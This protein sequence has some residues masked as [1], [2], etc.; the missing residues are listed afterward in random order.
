LNEVVRNIFAILDRKEKGTLGRLIAFDVIISLLDIVF[1]VALLYIVQF[2]TQSVHPAGT[3]RFPFSAFEKSPLWLIATFFLLFS[4]KNLAGFLVLRMQFRFVYGVASRLSRNNLALYLEG[5]YAEYV[6][7]N[8]SVQIRKINQHPIEFGHHVLGGFQQIVGQGLLILITVVATLIYNPVLF[9][10]LFLI[11]TPPIVLTGFLI[12]RKMGRVRR[13]AKPVSEKALQYLQEALAGFVDS[14]IYGREDF[15][16]R[17]YDT[18]QSAFNGFLADQQVIQNIP[19]KLI[20]VFAVFGFVVLV[21]INSYTGNTNTIQLIT[22]GAFMGAAYK[23]IPGIVK[24]LNSVGQIRTYGFTAADLV[25]ERS[26]HV[27]RDTADVEAIRSIAFSGVSFHYADEPVLSDFS[28]SI[29]SGE[30]VGLSGVSG[31][32]KTTVVNLLLGFMEPASGSISINGRVMS[33]PE[34]MGYWKQIAYVKQQP[35]MISDTVLRNIVLSEQAEDPA[36]LDMVI[37]RMGL[38][39]PGGIFPEGPEKMLTEDGRN[40]SGGQRQRIAFARALYKMAG[41]LVL[42]EPFNELDEASE[43]ALLEYCRQLAGEGTAILLITHSSKSLTACHKI[44]SL[45]GS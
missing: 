27:K 34:R 19:S 38:D 28:M 20:E 21:L 26:K 5:S 4:L 45:N 24:I 37:N 30:M 6:D 40:I 39:G 35:F 9:L 41:L 3:T 13:T 42:D 16:V 33:A 17:R 10:L 18:Y 29:S 32:G 43:W 8:S 11:L 31:K 2:F 23:I 15:F 14:S 44:V 36:R 1:L 7:I 12:R 22:I 25:R